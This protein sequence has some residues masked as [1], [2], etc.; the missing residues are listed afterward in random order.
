MLVKEEI[1]KNNQKYKDN[2]FNDDLRQLVEKRINI[3]REKLNNQNLQK[4]VQ[5][6]INVTRSILDLN[7]TTQ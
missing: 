2:S 1:N 6:R 5:K 3:T 7:N 4:L